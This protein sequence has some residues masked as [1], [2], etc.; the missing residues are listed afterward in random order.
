[1]GALEELGLYLDHHGHGSV[2]AN[3]PTIVGGFSPP[4]PANVVVLWQYPGPAPEHTIGVRAWTRPRLQVIVRDED[5]VLAASRIEA[6]F[7]L[8]D[9]LANV[10]IEG[11]HYLW[12]GA[13]QTPGFLRRDDRERFEWVVNFELWRT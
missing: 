7:E 9:G 12:I 5:T 4:D 6:I 3:P 1:M 2:T 11:R 10:D 8:L 13:V